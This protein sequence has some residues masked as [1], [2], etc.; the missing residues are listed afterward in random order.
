MISD[1]LSPVCFEY[2]F[3]VFPFFPADVPVLACGVR[4]VSNQ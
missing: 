1:A 3:A 4:F 2:T